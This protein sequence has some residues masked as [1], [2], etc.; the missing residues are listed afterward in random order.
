MV[1][2]E[3]RKLIGSQVENKIGQTSDDL[4]YW[5]LKEKDVFNSDETRLII[6][7]HSNCALAKRG[8]IEIKHADLVRED[9]CMI[10]TVTLRARRY[11][12]ISVPKI[13]FK[14]AFR[15][16]P[17]RGLADDISGVVYRSTAKGP[18]GLCTIL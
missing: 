9:N 5:C 14:N 8:E 12:H 4:K 10:I 7:L 17:I 18:H 2:P 11:G 1:S 15:S 13:N 3:M 16:Y 6:H